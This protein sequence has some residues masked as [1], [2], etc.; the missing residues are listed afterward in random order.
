MNVISTGV[1]CGL[2]LALQAS[3]CDSRQPPA[4]PPQNPSPPPAPRPPAGPPQ[5][6][7]PIQITGDERLTWDQS[8]LPGFDIGSYRFFIYIDGQGQPLAQASCARGPG[9]IFECGSPLPPMTAGRHRLQVQ[10]SQEVNGVRREGKLSGNILVFKTG[11]TAAVAPSPA[12]SAAPTDRAST[13]VE[14]GEPAASIDVLSDR[15]API[16]DLAVA[17]DG[18]VFAAERRGQVLALRG[19]AVDS[20]PILEIADAVTTNGL[21]LFSIALHPEY[22]SKK[23]VYVVYAAESRDGPVYRI[24]RGR[25][26]GGR[27][28][29][30][31]PLFTAGPVG[32]GGWAVLRF[33]PDGKLYAGLRPG[34]AADAV[35]RGPDDGQILRLNEDGTIPGDNPGSSPIVAHGHAGLSGL[36]FGPGGHVIARAPTETAVELAWYQGAI[37]IPA[38]RGPGLVLPV[39]GRPGG[40]AYESRS[41]RGLPDRVLLARLD[42]GLELLVGRARGEAQGRRARIAQDY[43]AIRAVAVA[44]D[45]TIYAATANG[46]QPTAPS[47]SVRDYLLRIRAP[48]P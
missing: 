35:G 21:G 42:G 18:G 2:L 45:G 27:V 22:E 24:G 20:N 43:G 7:N 11:G 16:A 44:P 3:S 14:T 13:P 4:P 31:A 17:P 48:Q 30:F 38:R 1:V 36:A 39:G 5:E 32:P 33:G 23:F 34:A 40:V 28:G 10:S 25:E 9:P 12:P 37:P 19:G 6:P 47:S 29:E 15:V 46:D 41:A 26:V 8:V